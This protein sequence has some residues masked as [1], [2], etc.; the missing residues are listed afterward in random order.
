MV[1]PDCKD[2]HNAH[3]IRR[4]T[5]PA[6]PVFRTSVPATCGKCHEGVER[7]YQAA[8]TATRSRR[9]GPTRRSA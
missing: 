8:C 2:C 9:G 4:R 1:A 3:D 5:D 7:R 6:S